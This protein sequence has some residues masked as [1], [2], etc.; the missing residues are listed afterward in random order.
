MEIPVA[1]IDA[2]DLD[3]AALADFTHVVLVDGSHES[4]PP[5]FAADLDAWTRAGGVLIASRGGAMWAAASGLAS[6]RPLDPPGKAPRASAAYADRFR[7]EAASSI[8]GVIFEIRLDP[9]HPIAWGYD[10]DSSY[11]H[12]AGEA[13]FASPP[14]GFRSVAWYPEHALASGYASDANIDRLAGATAVFAERRGQGAAVLFADDPLF[15]G[16][17]LASEKMVLN[18]LFF[19][20]SISP[21]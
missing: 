13:A 17:W 15:R 21:E 4:L 5:E 16:Y 12:R 7:L 9:T 3:P 20:R 19:A 18:A 1:M 14:S 8:G 2:E 10:S 6:A 11:V